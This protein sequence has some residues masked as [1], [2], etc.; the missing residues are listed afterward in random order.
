MNIK[1]KILQKLNI[2]SPTAE[3]RLPFNHVDFYYWKPRDGSLNFGD[4]LSY[5]IVSK[6]LADNNFIL[7]EET[8]DNSRLVALGS[9]LHFANNDDTIWGTGFNG[10]ISLDEH[11]YHNLDVRAVRG[12]LT[13]EFL[14]SRGIAV[15]QIYG[16]PALL[17]P[18]IFKGKFQ[19]S[20]QRK[21]AIVPNLHDLSI[22][23]ANNWK[24]V[25]SPLN[26]W[27]KCIAQI[28]EAE[29]IIASSLHGLI[30][31]ESFGIPARYIRLSEEENMF[32]YNDYYQGSGRNGEMDYARS[33]EEALEMG[34]MQALKFDHQKLLQAFPLDLWK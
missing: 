6:I 7:E 2:Q 14:L 9:V 1:E 21:Y 17:I 10:K 11:K 24:N 27:N 20:P 12:P 31:A 23:Q 33:I 16:D 15:P 29:F 13:R 30:L 8:T 4:H 19:K 5:V 3:F 18:H 28:L 34:G 22:A 25:I 32:K 26:S